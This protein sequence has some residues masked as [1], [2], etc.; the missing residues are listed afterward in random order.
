MA[1]NDPR[2][3]NDKGAKLAALRGRALF[4]LDAFDAAEPSPTWAEFRRLVERAGLSDVRSMIRDLRGAAAGLTPQARAQ[5]ERE[6]LDRF[7]PDEGWHR[8]RELVV[9]VRA[10]GHIKSEREYRVVQG[11]A[12][13]IAGDPAN[14]AEFLALGALLDNFSAAP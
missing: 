7:G 10:R 3:N 13:A 2:G 8:D 1:E 12:D 14:E 4:M 9:K 5:L 11:Y 6:L